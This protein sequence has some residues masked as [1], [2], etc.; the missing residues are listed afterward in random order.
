MRS[1][2]S[3][4]LLV[5]ACALTL[6]VAAAQDT[7][8]PRLEAQGA[9]PGASQTKL[10]HVVVSAGQAHIA[11][12]ARRLDANYWAAAADGSFGLPERLGPAEGQPDYSSAAIAATPDGTLYAAW[13]NQPERTIY[14]RSRPPGGAWSNP[15]VVVRGAPFPVN[16]AITAGTAGVFVAW[17]NPDQPFVFSRLRADQR[18][19]SPQP[20]SRAAGY[21]APGLAAGADR[22]AIAYTQGEADQLQIY[23]GLWEGQRFATERI[24]QLNA[25]YADPRI[26]IAPDGR[27]V[28]AWRGIADSGPTSGVFLAERAA[29]GAWPTAQIIGGKVIGPVTPAFDADGGL[30]LFWI[31]EAGGVLRLWYAQQPRGGAW[32]APV[33]ASVAGG[34]LFNAHGAVG[35]AASGLR[36]GH[37]VSEVF[38]GNRLTAHTFRFTAGGQSRPAATPILAAGAARSSADRIALDFRD[39]SGAPTEVRR[40]WGAPPTDADPWQPF[41]PTL[42]D[43]PAGAGRVACQE[44]RL[45]TQVRN[46]HGVQEAAAVATIVFDTG[47]Q[48]MLTSHNPDGLPGYARTPNAWLALDLADECSGIAAASLNGT[49]LQFD[50]AAQQLIPITLAAGEGPQ[51]FALHLTDGLGNSRAYTTTIV[52]DATAPEVQSDLIELR[53]DPAASVLQTLTLRNIRYR[54]TTSAAPWAVAV[55]ATRAEGDYGSWQTIPLDAHAITQEPDGS[56]TIHVGVSLAALLPPGTLHPGDYALRVRLVD[57][58]GNPTEHSVQATL[59]LHEITYPRLYLPALRR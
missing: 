31:G 7:P 42:I 16:V 27:V 38:I 33:S 15:S 29:D 59:K 4:L 57:P 26:A 39:V 34:A 22:A 51:Q 40:R 53:A 50:A 10:P 36:Y 37:A 11:A 8:T 46:A 5:C 43:A 49:S 23:A 9:L 52:Y 44:Q 56:L 30:H 48:A 3:A 28:A 1:F 24:T 54:D 17:R 35:A 45:Y 6:A 55:A 32:S 58:A 47:V 25:S 41:G 21:N 18:W 2:R 13:I 12:N 19:T 20:L 14:V